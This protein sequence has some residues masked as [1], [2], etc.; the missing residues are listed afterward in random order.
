M[1]LQLVGQHLEKMQDQLQ[2]THE[3][4]AEV[5]FVIQSLKDFSQVKEGEEIL[6]P[7]TNGVFARA[8]LKSTEKMIVNVG[9]ETAVHKSIPD[10]VSMLEGQKGRLV[11]FR[12]QLVDVVQQLMGKVGE[13][14]SE[15]Q[16]MQV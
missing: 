1:Q 12:D 2:K 9:A 5:D 11:Q 10:T 16:A 8:V 15:I 13:L 6:V 3:Q 7:V 4:I 14:R